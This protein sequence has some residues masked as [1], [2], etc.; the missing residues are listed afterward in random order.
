MINFDHEAPEMWSGM[1]ERLRRFPEPHIVGGVSYSAV[2]MC[3]DC[4]HLAADGSSM[5]C[6]L[7]GFRA[8]DQFMRGHC[9]WGSARKRGDRK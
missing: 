6:G 8:D 9:S 2:T 4:V 7:F 3:R 5:A 1:I